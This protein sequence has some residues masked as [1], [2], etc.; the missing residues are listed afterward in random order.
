MAEN[1]RI[2]WVDVAKGICMLSVIAGHLGVQ[3]LDRIVFSY[4]LTVF[5][6]LSGYTMKE[7][8]CPQAL[9]KRFKALMVPYFV[10]CGAV[11]VM[12][13]LNMMFLTGVWDFYSASSLVGADLTR[14]FFASGS[15]SS[16]G[17]IEIG[18]RIGAIWFLPALFFAGWTAQLLLKYIPNTAHRYAIAITFALLASI[19]ARFVW[20]PFSVQPAMLAVPLVLLGYDLKQNGL[21]ERLSLKQILLCFLIF[22]AGI[23]INKTTVYYVSADLPDYGISAVCAIASSLCIIYLAQKLENIHSLAWIGRN[24]IY[25]LCI[26]LFELETLE[27][28]RLLFM[29]KVGLPDNLF[30][31]FTLWFLFITVGTIV[32]KLIATYLRQRSGGMQLSLN[33]D[34]ALD[35]AKG[36]L[37]L[38]MLLGHSQMDMRFRNII[39][40]FHMAAFLFYSGY[41]FRSVSSASLAQRLMKEVKHLLLPYGLFAIGYMLLEKNSLLAEIR[42]ILFGMS[43]TQKVFTDVASIGPV[44]FLLLLF[45]TKCIYLLLNQYVRSQMW[46]SALVIILS[47]IGVYL[48]RMGYWLP[49]SADCALYALV[50]YHIGHLTRKYAILDYLAERG[51]WYFVLSTIW[52]YMVFCGGM[53]IAIR[54]Y[55]TYTTVVLGAVSASM[56]LY[57]ACRYISCNW[58]PWLRC[59]LCATGKHTLWILIVHTLSAGLIAEVTSLVF[60]PDGVV[61][62][63][64]TTILQV[65][66]GVLVGSL[67]QKIQRSVAAKCC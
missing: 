65:I 7:N 66:I 50:F 22:L 28:W 23:L 34:P 44:Y 56:M 18:G 64:V 54:N 27:T 14:S 37:I 55:G 63:T 12:D 36:I 15:I 46:K 48:G 30:I 17:Q 2:Q 29:D 13:L 24:S 31:R 1:R 59:M 38:L 16:L 43:F 10:T 61:F 9:Q 49:W 21:L 53:E 35:M 40:S 51:W 60:T 3:K 25:Y 67:I 33:R 19:S 8:L 58:V 42:N 26:H 20:L 4:H 52:V 47:L 41:C 62:V 6:L 11:I 32:I 39:Y 45:L 57:L 5:F